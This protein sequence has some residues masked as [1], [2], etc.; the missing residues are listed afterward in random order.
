MAREKRTFDLAAVSVLAI[1]LVFSL[2]VGSLAL[3]GLDLSVT[4]LIQAVIPRFFDTPLSFLSL[5]GTLEVTSL[6]LVILIWQVRELRPYWLFLIFGFGALVGVETFSKHFL[7]QSRPP[8]IYYRYS[9]PIVFPTSNVETK[10]A[11]PSGH[12]S[13]TAF[14]IVI[15]WFLVGKRVTVGRRKHYFLGLLSL[16][17]VMAVSRVYLGEHW[18]TDVIGGA[19]LGTAI[20]LGSFQAFSYLGDRLKFIKLP[21]D[22]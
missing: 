20:G 13:R 9:L 11:Y 12:M 7:G 17:L 18:L 8:S 1:F 6:V 21:L 3:N 14:L 19:I 5:L 4:K 22:S 15:F 10:Y 2:I 16:G